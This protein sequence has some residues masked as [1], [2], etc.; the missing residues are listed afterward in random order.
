[1]RIRNK[2][3]IHASASY[4]SG[5]GYTEFGTPCNPA[6][7]Q[8]GGNATYGSSAS[9]VPSYAWETMQDETGKGRPHAV[10]HRK[11]L[12]ECQ[13]PG[14][15]NV[16]SYGAP[17]PLGSTVS[18]NDGGRKNH[19]HAASS[20]NTFSQWSRTDKSTMPPY[21]VDSTPAWNESGVR[22]ELLDRAAQLKA[23]VLLNLVE[24]NQIVPSIRSLTYSMPTM[25]RNWKSIRKVIRTASGGY[26]AWKF[27]ISPILSDIM[28]INRFIPKAKHALERHGEQAAMRYSKAIP[29]R[30]SQTPSPYVNGYNPI[31]GVNSYAWEWDGGQLDKPSE[32]RYVLVVRPNTK[33]HTDFFKKADGLMSRFVTSPAS[34]AWEKIPFSFVIDW[35]VDLRGTLSA[36]D[37]VVGFSPYQIVAFTRSRQYHLTTHA[38]LRGFSCCSGANIFTVS[39]DHEYQHYERS[40]VSA[41]GFLPVWK[42]RVGKNQAAISVALISQ[43]LTSIGTTRAVS[44]SV[45]RFN[46][47]INNKLSIQ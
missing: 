26:L 6:I 10:I 35:F 3:S 12:Q 9:F 45:R 17:A 11:Y 28:A 44:A 20:Y 7:A 29:L 34:L 47:S 22:N 32:I 14:G 16:W 30:L 46:N 15:S 25:A 39:S 36:L 40:I 31:N 13:V 41:Q 2:D 21:W 37:R 42:P 38:T 33:F 1:M 24:A 5:Q 18:T 27:G 19:I 23:D 8:F 43:M 4:P